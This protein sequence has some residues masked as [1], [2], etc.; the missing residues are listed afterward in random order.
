MVLPK[1]LE[2]E[3]LDSGLKRPAAW[4]LALGAFLHFCG[5][6]AL[7]DYG[8]VASALSA[9][10]WQP[11]FLG[12]FTVSFWEFATEASWGLWSLGVRWRILLCFCNSTNTLNHLQTKL[13][14]LFQ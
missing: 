3:L 12:L 6:G 8:H 2:L 5:G 1:E 13:L 7:V 11:P 9:V 4:A 10:V 14:L